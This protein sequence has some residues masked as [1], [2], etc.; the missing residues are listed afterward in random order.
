MARFGYRKSSLKK[1]QMKTIRDQIPTILVERLVVGE[2]DPLLQDK[3][4]KVHVWTYGKYDLNRDTDAE[5]I[6]DAGNNPLRVEEQNAIAAAIKA[7]AMQYMPQGKT[8]SVHLRLM[9]YAFA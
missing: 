5:I 4:V 8:L 7:D 1:R 2:S 9:E 3:S 6:I